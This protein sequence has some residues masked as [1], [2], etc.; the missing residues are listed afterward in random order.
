MSGAGVAGDL[1]WLLDDLV[2]RVGQVRKVVVLSRDGLV[3]GASSQVSREDAEY[4][5]AL[6]AGFHSLAVGAKPHLGC[7]EVQQTIVEMEEGLFFVVPAGS[8][9]CLALLSEAGAN[10]GLVAYEMTMLVK[11]VRKQLAASPRTAE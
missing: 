5:A 10:A 1:N 7:G 4:L 11:R 2:Q 9:S 6:A 8:G 3:M